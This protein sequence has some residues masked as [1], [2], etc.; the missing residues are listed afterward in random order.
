MGL[1]LTRESEA[2]S[3]EGH[4]VEDSGTGEMC[5]WRKWS[6]AI[7]GAS[8]KRSD[9]GHGKSEEWCEGVAIDTHVLHM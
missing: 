6:H 1:D 8:V 4:A 3:G 9:T 7:L 5:G 2:D